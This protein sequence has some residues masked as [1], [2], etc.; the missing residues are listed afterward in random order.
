M[1]VK[2]YKGMLYQ[3]HKMLVLI[4]PPPQFSFQV[5][6][7]INN[8]RPLILHGFSQEEKE[9]SQRNKILFLFPP[10]PT[11]IRDLHKCT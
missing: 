3:N 10:Y 8:F 4:N 9:Y 11:I 6:K 2:S 7:F 1:V 5:S